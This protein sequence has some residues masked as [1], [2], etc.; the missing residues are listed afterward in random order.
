M[1]NPAELPELV[2][3]FVQMS[4]DYLRQETIEPAKQLGRFAGFSMAAGLMFAFGVFFLSIAGMRGIIEML[5]GGKYAKYWESL[6]YFLAA[7]ALVAVAGII[8]G[9]AARGGDDK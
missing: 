7:L 1:A 9:L 6:G 4:K 2:S 8:V 3:E 5:P